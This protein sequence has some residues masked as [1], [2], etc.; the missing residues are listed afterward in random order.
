MRYY[1]MGHILMSAGVGSVRV[2]DVIR[3]TLDVL[4]PGDVTVSNIPGRSDKSCLRKG[5]KEFTISKIRICLPPSK[6]RKSL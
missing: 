3:Q 1:H 6:L 4:A 2:S 5:H